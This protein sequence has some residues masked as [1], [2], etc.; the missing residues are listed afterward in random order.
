[1]LGQ[2]FKQFKEEYLNDKRTLLEQ[3]MK[4]MKNYALNNS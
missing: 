1:M 4:G 2:I 3:V